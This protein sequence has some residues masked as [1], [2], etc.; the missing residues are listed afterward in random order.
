MRTVFGKEISTIVQWT[1][2]RIHVFESYNN[3]KSREKELSI[4][5]LNFS[6]SGCSGRRCCYCCGRGCSRFFLCSNRVGG[7]FP[8]SPP[9]LFI[10]CVII[11]P[12]SPCVAIIIHWINGLPICLAK[13]DFGLVRR[14]QRGGKSVAPVDGEARA[15]NL[16]P[17][18]ER[19]ASEDGMQT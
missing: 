5:N 2:T 4:E 16:N 14:K 19:H 18:A 11:A 13:R 17:T 7:G 12:S 15:S 3:D 8:S 1:C 10:L 6:A 9:R